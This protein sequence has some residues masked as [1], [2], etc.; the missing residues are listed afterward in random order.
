MAVDVPARRGI[1]TERLQFEASDAGGDIEPGLSLHTDR[2]Q[3]VSI[4]RTADQE[5]A[6]AADADGRVGADAAIVPGQ[7]AASK[8]AVRRAHRPG[9][10]GL[11][12][13]A[14][15]D[16]NPAHG[17][18]VRLRPAAFALK[19]AFKAGHGADDEADILAALALQ[20]AGAHR[21]QRVS[22]GDWRHQRRD[23]DAECRK[24][25][26]EWH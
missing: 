5:V 20:D 24:A 8:P 16:A 9:E 14:E 13:E 21:G 1:A 6:A 15:L 7:F 3:S 17:C 11:F 4:R 22:A 10:S 23:G 25:R 19:H 18:E 2:L 12:G 26:R